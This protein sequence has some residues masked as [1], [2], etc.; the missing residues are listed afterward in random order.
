MPPVDIT[1][2]VNAKDIELD[3]FTKSFITSTVLGMLSPLRGMEDP[4]ALG[5]VNIAL[6]G[7]DATVTADGVEI[8]MNGFVRDIVRNTTKAMVEPLRGVDRDIQT[9]ELIMLMP[10]TN[11]P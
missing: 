5:N 9:V 11:Q 10:L 4:G 8:G 1:L 7:E 6:C 2:K 3:K